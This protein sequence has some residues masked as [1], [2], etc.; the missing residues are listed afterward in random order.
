AR[1]M[2]KPGRSAPRRPCIEASRAAPVGTRWSGSGDE[3]LSTITLGVQQRGEVGILDPGAGRRGDRRFGPERHAKSRL[4]KHREII[5][6]VSD[7][8][9]FGRLQPEP[10]PQFDE[11][12]ELR[13]SPDDW[14]RNEA[15]K[16]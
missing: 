12:S 5:R 4:L 11:S 8:K 1:A 3:F 7:G 16:S 15:G 10:R 13:L 14:L 2:T 6:S 9:R